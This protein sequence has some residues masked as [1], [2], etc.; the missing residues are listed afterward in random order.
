MNQ[1]E[2]DIKTQKQV[3]KESLHFTGSITML[4][5]FIADNFYSI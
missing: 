4:M 1:S 3:K 5:Y 2:Y